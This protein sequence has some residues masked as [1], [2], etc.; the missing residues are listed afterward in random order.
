[1]CGRL[2]RR[3]TAHS[4]LSPAT[5]EQGG[6]RDAHEVVQA[7][8]VAFKCLLCCELWAVFVALIMPAKILV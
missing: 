8:P 6:C 4:E 3:K 5:A 2:L 7:R 1:M